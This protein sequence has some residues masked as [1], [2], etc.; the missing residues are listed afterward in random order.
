MKKALFV[1]SA[2]LSSLAFASA[3]SFTAINTIIASV[4]GIVTR[5]I[6]LAVGLAILAFFFFL[7]KFIW[8]SG[9]PSGRADSLRGMGYSVLALFVMVSI[10][11]LVGFIGSA[12]G[13]GQGGSAPIPTV[14]VAQ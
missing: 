4:Q 5:L 9:D 14:Q 12:L 13:V 6:P 10:W 7:V 2:T 8:N 3:Q 11:G 1:L